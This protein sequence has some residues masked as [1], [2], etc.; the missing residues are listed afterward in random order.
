ML[1]LSCNVPELPSKMEC[2]RRKNR[3]INTA[4][5][6]QTAVTGWMSNSLPFTVDAEPGTESRGLSMKRRQGFTIGHLAKEAGV[7][8]ETIRYYH[9]IGL[10]P[11]PPAEPGSVVRVY[12]D[13]N[14]KQLQFIKRA[15]RLGF[16]LEEIGSFIALSNGN[17]CADVQAMAREKLHVLEEKMAEITNM[18][19]GIV[20]LL[21]DCSDN[22][23]EMHCPFIEA[24]S[25]D[26]D[27]HQSPRRMN[28]NT[29]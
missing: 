27:M 5:Q 20:M 14:L 17:H 10:L 29:H 19:D 13:E 24:L 9:R 18:R 15:Q 7:C 23:D 6:H 16:S 25:Q 3:G 21:R 12:G 1:L 26:V 11:I 4:D 22:D 28:R 2:L 8:V